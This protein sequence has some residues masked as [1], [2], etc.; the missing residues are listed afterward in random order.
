MIRRTVFSRSL[1]LLSLPQQVSVVEGLA[2][3]VKSIPGLIPLSDQHLLAFLSELLKMLSVADGE[4][5]DK[6]FK[7]TIVDKNG[8]VEPLSHG[9]AVISRLPMLHVFSFGGNALLSR[10]Q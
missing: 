7:T 10:R 3:I 4:M 2:V 1:R 9:I 5:V 6:N 8:F